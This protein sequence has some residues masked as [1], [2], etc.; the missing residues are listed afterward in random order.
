MP[1]ILDILLHLPSG[2]VLI[3]VLLACIAAVIGLLM[4]AITPPLMADDGD[5]K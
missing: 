5:W 1:E 2:W 3:A 4:Y